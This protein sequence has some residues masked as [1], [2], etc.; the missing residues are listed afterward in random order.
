MGFF[1]QATAPL[2]G[3]RLLRRL[4]A[5]ARGMRRALERQAD[6]LEMA[7]RDTSGRETLGG[8]VFRSYAQAKQGLTDQDVRD[9]TDVSYVDEQVLA[10]MLQAEEELRVILG[11]DPSE[12]EIEAA[13]RGEIL[14]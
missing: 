3:Y 14:G 7:A 8:Q 9:L 6:A 4:L 10:G 2:K 1:S 11:R 5:E 12:Q 13:Y